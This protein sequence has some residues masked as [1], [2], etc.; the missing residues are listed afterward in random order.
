MIKALR[1]R[2]LLSNVKLY[3]T[4]KFVKINGWP[5]GGS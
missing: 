1:N 3:V 2:T 4:R 5:L